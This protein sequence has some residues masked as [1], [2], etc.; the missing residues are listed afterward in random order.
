M[1]IRIVLGAGRSGFPENQSGHLDE[2]DD[3]GNLLLHF[4]G[5]LPEEG[6]EINVAGPSLEFAFPRARCWQFRQAGSRIHPRF[7]RQRGRRPRASGWVSGEDGRGWQDRAREVG[8]NANPGKTVLLVSAV[9]RRARSPR[10]LDRL[11]REEGLKPAFPAIP[12][13]AGA[14]N[15]RI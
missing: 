13:A 6:P 9:T 12:A 5:S 8:R 11:W 7:P 15:R 14:P 4:L 3:G 2:S 1:G 10:D